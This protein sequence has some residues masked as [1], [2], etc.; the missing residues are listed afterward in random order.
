MTQFDEGL[1]DVGRDN[2]GLSPRAATERSHTGEGSFTE[3]DRSFQLAGTEQRVGLVDG[4]PHGGFQVRGV[5]GQDGRL[6]EQLDAACPV[7]DGKFMLSPQIH[8]SCRL[9][10]VRPPRPRHGQSLQEHHLL[11]L[12]RATG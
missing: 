5:S 11:C 1:G 7:A 10:G 9:V 3:H 2:G 12:R 6:L 8:Q 4:D